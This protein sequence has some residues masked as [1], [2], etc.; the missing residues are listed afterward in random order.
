MKCASQDADVLE[1][2]TTIM[3]SMLCIHEVAQTLGHTPFPAYTV[4]QMDVL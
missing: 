3:F 1:F 4:L 2:T